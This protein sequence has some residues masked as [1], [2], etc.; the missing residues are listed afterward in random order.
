[1]KDV[2]A[3]SVMQFLSRPPTSFKW[4]KRIKTFVPQIKDELLTFKPLH[5]CL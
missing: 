5:I 2:A 1:M 3:S 4:L